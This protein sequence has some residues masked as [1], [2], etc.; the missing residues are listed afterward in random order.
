MFGSMESPV[1]QPLGPAAE[2]E[3]FTYIAAI[4]QPL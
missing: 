3:T 4:H 2:V 1:A